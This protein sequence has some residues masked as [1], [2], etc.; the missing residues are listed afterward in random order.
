M[1]VRKTLEINSRNLEACRLMAQLAE[2]MRSPQAI[3]W[4]AQIVDLEPAVTAN[5][6]D[7]ARTALLFGDISEAGNALLLIADATTNT[8]DYQIVAFGV[9][10]GEKD[11]A[12][13]EAH[14]VRA[15]QLDPQNK[16]AQYNLAVLHLQ[17]KDTNVF[18][19]ALS[20]MEKLADAPSH[21]RDALRALV[22]A[23][24]NRGDF[25]RA[26]QYSARLESNP[27]ALFE[28]RLLHL[29]SLRAATNINTESY[30]SSL[31]L[32]AATNLNET[33]VLAGWLRSHQMSDEALAWLNGLPEK[34][35]TEPQVT[36]MI[37]GCYADRGDWAS[38]QAILEKQKWGTLDFIRLAMLARTYREQKQD[39]GARASWNLAITAAANQQSALNSLFKM[40]STWG[41]TKEEE[42]LAWYILK[43]FP[44][45]RS[46]LARL[47]QIYC[48][49]GNTRGLQKVYSALLRYEQSKTDRVTRNNFAALSL[50]LNTDTNR[51]HQIAHENYTQNPE[52]KILASTYAY[53]LFLQGRTEEG[54]R[55]IEHLK[56]EE[57]QDPAVAT[58]YGILLVAAGQREKAMPFLEI[59]LKAPL[60]LPEE[61]KLVAQAASPP[62]AN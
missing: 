34:M 3:S 14:C 15:A 36:E 4:R 59:A 42:A 20:A 54:L 58:Y 57:L 11:L 22:D 49:A 39:S 8:V 23:L 12:G 30:L 56:P 53:S 38:A 28:D 7:L 48:A 21:R 44:Q 10:I 24:L 47:N 31:R 37:A 5:R 46:I 51:A 41:W 45:E 18:E 25:V 32:Q 6:L 33:S 40:A 26:R 9:S 19:Q 2:Q 29:T 52:D 61:K 60:A 16:S 62:N 35:R 55:T 1:N 27:S 43:R 50:L 17:S 13:A